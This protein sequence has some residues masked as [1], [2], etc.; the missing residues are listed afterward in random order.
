MDTSDAFRCSEGCGG[1]R[2]IH[3]WNPD[4]WRYDTSNAPAS[5]PV[6]AEI[7]LIYTMKIGNCIAARVLPD[8]LP[9]EGGPYIYEMYGN[10]RIQVEPTGED[11]R[12]EILLETGPTVTGQ[13]IMILWPSHRGGS[14][15][16]HFTTF[17]NTPDE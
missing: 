6:N 11:G 17:D 1:C 7:R 13:R 15:T 9:F 10:G 16:F 3:V 4:G 5:F 12:G 2:E 14:Y 8:L